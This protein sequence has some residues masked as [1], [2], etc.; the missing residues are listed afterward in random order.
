MQI[1]HL[2]KTEPNDEKRR[3]KCL[4][5]LIKYEL[6]NFPITSQDI[7]EWS[8]SGKP[9]VQN[10]TPPPELL[11]KWFNRIQEW[12]EL[13][14][15]E[16]DLSKIRHLAEK[17]KRR[18]EEAR[19][20][21]EE[22]IK[23]NREIVYQERGNVCFVD[24]EYTAEDPHELLSI[25]AVITHQAQHQLGCF[26]QTVKPRFQN[27][28][29]GY[30]K[31]ITKLGQKEIDTSN[32]FCEVTADFLDFLKQYDAKQLYVWGDWDRVALM[33]NMDLYQYEGQFLNWVERMIDLQRIIIADLPHTRNQW[34]LEKMKMIYGM[35]TAV[36]H[37][38]LSDAL[39]LCDVFYA[40]QS[41]KPNLEVAN[42]FL[43]GTISLP[44]YTRSEEKRL[45]EERKSKLKFMYKKG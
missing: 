21:R 35:D 27:Q 37:H 31:K 10:A 4:K 39:D 42:G 6:R 25:G 34:G 28:L 23:K 20:K 45:A 9:A 19:R 22:T 32:D 41:R 30:T 16:A 13:E 24:F 33:R 17:E 18:K 1:Q 14:G 26:Y 40:T 36:I 8:K 38:A 43:N 7:W 15:A 29:S 2:V 12:L 44:K 11:D 5:I 3:K